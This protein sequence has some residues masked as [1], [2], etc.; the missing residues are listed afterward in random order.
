MKLSEKVDNRPVNKLIKF[1]WRSG[2]TSGYRD[3]FPDSLLLGDTKSAW[4]TDINLLLI[5]IRQMAALVR[6]TL[7]EVCTV[8]LLLVQKLISGFS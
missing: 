7:A 6:L 8:P 1:R 4:L 2:S 3:C 5:L